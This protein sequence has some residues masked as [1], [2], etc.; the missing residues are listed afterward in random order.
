MV[1]GVIYPSCFSS[2]NKITGNN[3]VLGGAIMC[4]NEVLKAMLKSVY[5]T[6]I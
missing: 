3:K 4:P 1:S 2:M 5:F 6:L